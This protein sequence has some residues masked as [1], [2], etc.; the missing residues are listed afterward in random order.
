MDD[1][2]AN[3]LREQ[4]AAAQGALDDAGRQRVGGLGAFTGKER[5]Q[6]AFGILAS[7][8]AQGF[9][10]SEAGAGA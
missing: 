6:I 7:L 2:L 1:I 8:P 10:V 9:E 3:A 4:R 5:R